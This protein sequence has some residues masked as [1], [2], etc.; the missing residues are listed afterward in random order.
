MPRAKGKPQ[1]IDVVERVERFRK[2]DAL[3]LELRDTVVYLRG[4]M[5]VLVRELNTCRQQRLLAIS[6]Q[7]PNDP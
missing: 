1:E 7:A 4:E 6:R 3:H 2:A 5:A